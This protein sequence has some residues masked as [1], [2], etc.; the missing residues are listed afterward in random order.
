MSYNTKHWAW[1]KKLFSVNPKSTDGMPVTGVFRTPAVGSRPEKY[2][3]PKTDASKVHGNY[4]FQRDTRRNFPR[5]AVYTQQDVAGLLTGAGVE[6]SL[7]APGSDSQPVT[8]ATVTETKSLT[9]VL[10]STSL[11]SQSK[12]PPTPTWNAPKKWEISSD[13]KGPDDGSYFPMRN[14]V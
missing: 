2:V 14:F 9:E 5:L 10:G 8:P 6:P 1:V 3:Y 13:F 12:L 7:P 4:Y 11:Y